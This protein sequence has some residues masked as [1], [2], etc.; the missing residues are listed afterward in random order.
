[1]SGPLAHLTIL[2]LTRVL[3]GPWCTQLLADLGANVLKI[4]RPGTGDDTRAWGP[5]FLKD[6]DG[7][8]THESAYYLACNRGKRSVA[9]DFTT[10]EG[11]D[12]VL[13]LAGQSD[14]LVENFKVGGLV[15]Y[16]LDYAR[17]AAI[18]AR[19]V[20]ASI[21]GFGQTGPYAARAGYDFI[22]QG[23]SGFMSVTGERDD[24]PGGGPQKAGVAITDLMT[25]MYAC[26]ALLG[27]LAH[28]DRTGEGQWIDAS[29]FDSSVAMMAVI[30]MN[31]LV[32]GR[33]PERAGNAHQNIVPYQ[34]FAC[35]DGHVIVAVG[36][37][38]QFRAFCAIAGRPEWAGDP[39]FATNAARVRHR[40]ALVPMIDAL[41]RTRTRREWLAALEAAG[42]PGGPI[43]RIDQ[44][45]ADPQVKARGMSIDLPHPLA[46]SVPQVRAPL[47]LSG[48][49]LAYERAPPLLGADTAA[50]LRTRL[51]IDD[52]ALDDLARRGVIGMAGAGA[53]HASGEASA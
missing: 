13:A 7:N 40:E 8:D 28:R 3:A 10:P 36:N 48:T 17:V 35:A 5:P 26:V 14:A 38:G 41:M 19:L 11:R 30:H 46:G 45:F 18:N 44:V 42:I 51:G 22:I 37:D 39:R 27:A 23:M 9:I 21:T 33:V 43:N 52:S 25:G 12:L 53:G 15:K 2:D 20:Y 47:A 29:L 1:M 34:A 49:P 16:G 4:E 32:S 31:Y 50:V 6:R 24:V